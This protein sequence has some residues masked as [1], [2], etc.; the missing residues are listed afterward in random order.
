MIKSKTESYIDASDKS[1]DYLNFTP[2]LIKSKKQRVTMQCKDDE[3][4]DKVILRKY[5][6]TE[7]EKIKKKISDYARKQVIKCRIY[8]CS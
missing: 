5:K 3:E 7:N 2:K 6:G 4:N 1:E 8:V